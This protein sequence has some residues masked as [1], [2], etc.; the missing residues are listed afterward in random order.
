MRVSN[1]L[2]PYKVSLKT[3][4]FRTHIWICNTKILCEAA[5]IMDH[6][7]IYY[8]GYCTIIKTHRPSYRQT[9]QHVQRNP[10]QSILQYRDTQA[11]QNLARI[12][13]KRLR[14]VIAKISW[15]RNQVQMTQSKRG[16]GYAVENKR[17]R[18]DTATYYLIYIVVYKWV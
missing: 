8:I 2:K 9:A 11:H 13:P 1:T 10:I 4:W 18:L 12:L 16:T 14:K 7:S 6:K 17:I 5:G 3:I 15:S